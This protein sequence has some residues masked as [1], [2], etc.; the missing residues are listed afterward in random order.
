MSS[1]AASDDPDPWDFL[2]L[3]RDAFDVLVSLAEGDIWIDEREIECPKHGSTFS[4]V[5]GEPQSLPA[6]Q[7]V[8]VY[9]VRIDGDDVIVS[10]Q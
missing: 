6:T 9:D 10:V 8:P 2:P 5:D 3:T 7:P 4:L 1:R